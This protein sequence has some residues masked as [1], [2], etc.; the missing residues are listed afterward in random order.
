VATQ[1]YGYHYLQDITQPVYP[2]IQNKGAYEAAADLIRLNRTFLQEELVAR[3]E[4][5]KTTS[6]VPFTPAFTYNKNF[7]N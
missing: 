4:F 1:A 2:K 5:N 7:Y 3:I 6:V